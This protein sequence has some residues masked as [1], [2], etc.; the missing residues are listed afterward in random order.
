[1]LHCMWTTFSIMERSGVDWRLEIRI[2]E[3]KNWNDLKIRH[4]HHCS[5]W[6]S[7][8]VFNIFFL[9]SRNFLFCCFLCLTKRNLHM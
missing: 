2:G 7:L 8:L 3:M 4:T 6:F 9:D 1:M 5:P